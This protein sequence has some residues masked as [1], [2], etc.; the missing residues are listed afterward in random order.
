MAMAADQHRPMTQDSHP[1]KAKKTIK[2]GSGGGKLRK[3]R[4]KAKARRAKARSA[5]KGR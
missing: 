4:K 3:G 1:L 5:I 2:G